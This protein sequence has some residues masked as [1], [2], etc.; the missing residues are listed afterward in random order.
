MERLRLKQHRLAMLRIGLRADRG[1]LRLDLEAIA[2]EQRWMLRQG[3]HCALLEI[4]RRI[5]VDQLN[6]LTMD[7]GACI[8]AVQAIGAQIAI[9]ER[10][11]GRSRP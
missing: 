8:E 2:A 4:A 6:G 3:G 5:L 7:T 10:M 1:T 9:R 11:A